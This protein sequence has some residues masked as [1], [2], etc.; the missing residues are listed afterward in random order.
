MIN[1]TD[2]LPLLILIVLIIWLPAIYY[3]IGMF[4]ADYRRVNKNDLKM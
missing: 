1:N 4:R 2:L 3:E